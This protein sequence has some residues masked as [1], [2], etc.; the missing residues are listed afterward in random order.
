MDGDHDMTVKVEL[1]QISDSIR[2]LTQVSVS[3]TKTD[4]SSI[5]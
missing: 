2:L 3:N 5:V 4:Y 1:S